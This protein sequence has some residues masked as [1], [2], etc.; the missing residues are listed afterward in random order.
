MVIECISELL[1]LVLN[2]EIQMVVS[3]MYFSIKELH[4]PAKQVDH[5][6]P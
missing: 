2:G 5:G 3:S 1:Q 4:A 6:L